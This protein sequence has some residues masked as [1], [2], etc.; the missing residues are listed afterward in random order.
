MIEDKKIETSESIVSTIKTTVDMLDEYQL[1]GY[2]FDGS[3]DMRQILEN[4]LFTKVHKDIE[5]LSLIESEEE[6]TK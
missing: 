1:Y 2:S 3:I 4:H 6:K 5:L